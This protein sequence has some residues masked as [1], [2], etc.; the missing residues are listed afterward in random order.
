MKKVFI[1]AVLLAI[2]S[3]C[4][5]NQAEFKKENMQDAISRALELEIPLKRLNNCYK[6]Y[7]SYYLFPEIGKDSGDEISDLFYYENQSAVMC[8]DVAGIIDKLGVAVRYDSGCEI[9]SF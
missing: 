3:G 1:L 2:L 9:F 4:A 7:Y 6:P 5:S 8:L